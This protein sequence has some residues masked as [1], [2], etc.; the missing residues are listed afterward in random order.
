M[1][2]KA[3]RIIKRNPS[4]AVFV[5]GLLF[6]LGLEWI[7]QPYAIRGVYFQRWSSEDMMQT[8][9]VVD[10]RAEPLA[11]L[12]YLHVQPPL[13]DAIRAVLA[14]LWP[15]VDAQ[16]LVVN[17]DRAL[18]VVWAVV[19][20]GLGAL[21]CHWLT[22]LINARW[23]VVGS[24][25]FLLHPAAIFYAT[26]LENTLLFSFLI[27]WSYYALWKLAKRGGS[28]VPL[29]ISVVLLYLTRALVQWPFLL[30]YVIVL[31]LL[32]VPWRKVAIFAA[33]VGAVMGLYTLKQMTLFGV[34]YTSSFAGL[35]CYHGLGDYLDRYPDVGAPLP[36]PAEVGVLTTPVKVT[37]VDNFNTM[38]YLK[39]HQTLL[40]S[41]LPRLVSKPISETLFAYFSNFVNYLRPS[42]QFT[43][44][45]IIADRLPWRDIYNALFSGGLLLIVLFMA[46]VWWLLHDGRGHLRQGLALLLPAMAIL[47]LSVGF[48]M[49]E[50]MR[51]KFFL[52]PLLYVFLVSQLYSLWQAVRRAGLQRNTPIGTEQ[53]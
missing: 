32:R 35:N 48:E 52:E 45:H 11:S 16:T 43:T 19:Y 33:I 31:W 5:L 10:L 4:L 53:A 27:A 9:S 6:I 24:I 1:F 15:T 38:L 22:Q 8:V 25:V 13:L 23:G 12:Y 37:G 36:P 49:G 42:A 39:R 18:Y 7:M 44:P 51:Y 46:G 28:I 34:T 26:F 47:V 2:R 41:C 21:L 40:S 50:N 17:V 30:L 20:A 14:Q 29:A 3:W